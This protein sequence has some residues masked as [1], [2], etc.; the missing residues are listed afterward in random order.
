[1]VWNPFR[2]QLSKKIKSQ[3]TRLERG[4]APGDHIPPSTMQRSSMYSLHSPRTTKSYKSIWKHTANL[5]LHSQTQTQMRTYLA[6]QSQRQKTM[7]TTAQTM[8][9]G[10]HTTAARA[11]TRRCHRNFSTSWKQATLQRISCRWHSRWTHGKALHWTARSLCQYCPAP[12]RYCWIVG[13]STTC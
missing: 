9:T 12:P 8:K 2:A 3:E 13:H 7:N 11:A 6:S 10:N 5:T 1:M 4:E